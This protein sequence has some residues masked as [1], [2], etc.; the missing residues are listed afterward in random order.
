VGRWTRA[1]CSLLVSAGAVD[2]LGAAAAQLAVPEVR[3]ESSQDPQGFRNTCVD[4]PQTTSSPGSVELS[5]TGDTTDSLEVAYEV[6]GPEGDSTGTATFD[7]GSA[8]ATIEVPFQDR[9]GAITWALV[10][11]VEYDL[12]EPSSVTL[13]QLLATTSCAAT[14]TTTLGVLPATGVSGTPGL[15]AAG[16]GLVVL[17]LAL[18]LASR[19]PTRR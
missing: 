1:L 2:P 11:A 4:P 15:P 16:L 19:R 12:G 13:S 14:T 18:A 10:D 17:G 5:R 3:I 9:A 7:A 8:T 6:V